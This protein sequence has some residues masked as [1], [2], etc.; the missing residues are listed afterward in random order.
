MHA[1]QFLYL[2]LLLSLN[3]VL[4]SFEDVLSRY[5]QQLP[6]NQ[7]QKITTPSLDIVAELV[8]SLLGIIILAQNEYYYVHDNVTIYVGATL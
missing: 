2:L 4:Q 8:C 3:N 6:L 5:A 1:H 7:N